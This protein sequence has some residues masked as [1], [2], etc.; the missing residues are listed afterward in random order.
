MVNFVGPTRG[1]RL[2]I[3]PARGPAIL[4]HFPG[5]RASVEHAHSVIL[6]QDLGLSAQDY[7]IGTRAGS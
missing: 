5:I 3:S 1:R 4:S 6:G 2:A 7:A